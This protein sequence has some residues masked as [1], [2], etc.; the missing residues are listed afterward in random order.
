MALGVAA[1]NQAVKEGRA[2]QTERVLRNPAVALRGVLPN[3]AHGYQRALEGAM[4]K[5]Q[6]PGNS[7]CPARRPPGPLAPAP[8]SCRSCF[9]VGEAALWVP[10]NQ[11]DGTFYYLH[12]QS[13]EGTWAQ[14]RGCRLNTSHLTREEIQV[15]G[16]LVRGGVCLGESRRGCTRQDPPPTQTPLWVPL[17][18]AVTKVTAAHDRRLLWKASEGFVTRLQARL[19]GFLARQLFSERAHFLRTQLPA[20]L[21][22]QVTAPAQAASA[23]LGW[24]FPPGA[25]SARSPV[26]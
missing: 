5:K 3:C 21:I 22:I 20:V 18:A 25:S 17:Q 6:R 19:R 10:H 12:L 13:F 7:P 1:I 8:F 14:P 2:A 9:C 15:A 23:S 16:S 26:C 11:Q 24:G 4:A